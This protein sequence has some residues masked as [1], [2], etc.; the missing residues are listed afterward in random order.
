MTLKPN[1]SL[2]FPAY[3]DEKTIRVVVERALQL[4]EEVAGVYE[5]IIV[6]DGSPDR[7]GEIADEL[8][9][10]HP[11]IRVIHHPENLGYGAALKTGVRASRYEWIC[12]V[13]GDNEY[14]VYELK[15]MLY[16]KDYYRLV[17]AFRYVKLYS[18]KRVFISFVYNAVLRFMFK[19]P[20]RD[21]STGIRLIHSSVLNEIRLSS[22]SPFIG[23]ELTLK[24]M[25]RGVPVG[26]VGIQTFPR[27]FGSGSA[28]SIKNIFRTVQDIFRI[29]KEIFSN[30][31]DLPEGRDREK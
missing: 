11:S 7:S 22:D 13:D 2:F 19:S 24:A 20:Y 17:I 1:I 31:Y 23:A 21:I 25:L 8:S 29:R 4:L 16:V 15:K 6:D 3:K 9:R 14:D 26:E 5:I 28:T 30:V 12:M 18:T 27:D 10:E